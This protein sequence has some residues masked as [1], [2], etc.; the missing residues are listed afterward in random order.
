MGLTDWIHSARRGTGLGRP[1]QLYGLSPKE[2]HNV[3]TQL[4]P[5][6]QRDRLLH[7]HLFADADKTRSPR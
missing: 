6:L 2:T 5:A 3:L 4:A 7:G 1:F